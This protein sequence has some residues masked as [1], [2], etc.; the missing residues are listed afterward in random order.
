[1]TYGI[2]A[3]AYPPVLD[4]TLEY[5]NP[6]VEMVSDAAGPYLEVVKKVSTQTSETLAQGAHQIIDGVL[7]TLGR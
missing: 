1:M 4:V 6:L 7:K 3:V 5:L 2:A